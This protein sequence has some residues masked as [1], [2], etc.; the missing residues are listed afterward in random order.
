LN[1][2]ATYLRLSRTNVAQSFQRAGGKFSSGGRNLAV[3]D[4]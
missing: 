4:L 1:V 2:C 3:F